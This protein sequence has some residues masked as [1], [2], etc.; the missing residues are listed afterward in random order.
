MNDDLRWAVDGP[1]IGIWTTVQGTFDV[2]MQ[3]TLWLLSDG[4]GYLQSRSALRGTERF[5]VKW[6]Q[7]QPGTLLMAILYPGDDLNADTEWET[8][9]YC[10][11][12]TRID[13]GGAHVPVLRN[14]DD[15]RFWNLV[16]P[17]GFASPVPSAGGMR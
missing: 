3:D 7:V 10:N 12:V 9:L 15:N 8:V 16:G 2:I 11:A 17:I 1:P 5:P 14:I 13:A 4:T 6:K